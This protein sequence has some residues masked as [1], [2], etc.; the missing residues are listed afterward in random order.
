VAG[1]TRERR[2]ARGAVT[3]DKIRMRVIEYR[4][5]VEGQDVPEMF[6]LITGLHDWRA[7]PAGVLAAAYRWRWD[8]SE[9]ALR[10]ARSAIRGAGPGRSSAPAPRT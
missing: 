5:E 7:Y 9:T 1:A 6:C 4:V 10:E 8:G 2:D 3:G